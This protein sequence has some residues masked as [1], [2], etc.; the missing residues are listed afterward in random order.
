LIGL[1]EIDTGG[2]SQELKALDVFESRGVNREHAI[3]D[4]EERI[5]KDVARR[6]GIGSA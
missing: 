3:L 4:P 5:Q 6:V 2:F 1:S